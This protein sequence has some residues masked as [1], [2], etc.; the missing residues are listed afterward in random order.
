MSRIPGFIDKTQSHLANAAAE[1]EK[2]KDDQSL[3]FAFHQAGKGLTQVGD[4][5]EQ[6]KDLLS[7]HRL[8]NCL[9]NAKIPIKACM[10][11]AECAA[12]VF[13]HVSQAPEGSRFSIYNKLLSTEGSGLMVE[14]LL[15]GMVKCVCELVS[16]TG[17]NEEM[18]DHVEDLQDFVDRIKSMQPSAMVDEQ[19]AKFVSMEGPQYNAAGFAEQNNNTGAG[20]QFPGATFQGEVR[21]GNNKPEGV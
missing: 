7:G 19:G 14:V 18:R 13:R 10:S 1:Y 3:R 15:E 11:K 6:L 9:H 20:N 5:L 16:E 2:V 8:D 21:I 17:C 4:L 12:S